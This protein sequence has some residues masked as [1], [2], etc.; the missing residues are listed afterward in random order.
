M[1]ADLSMHSYRLT[2]ALALLAAI[3]QPLSSEAAN[4]TWST[5]SWSPSQQ[6]GSGDGVFFYSSGNDYTSTLGANYTIFRLTVNNIGNR[7]IAPGG[8]NILTLSAFDGDGSPSAIQINAGAGAVLIQS[9]LKLDPND[10]DDNIISV[11]NEAGLTITQFATGTDGFTKEGNGTLFLNLSGN[12][13]IARYTAIERGTVE[14]TSGNLLQ[15]WNMG[16]AD[17]AGSN[18]TLN[19]QSG[20]MEVDGNFY[21]GEEGSGTVNVNG[22]NLTLD[23]QV[24]IGTG[25]GTA[26][27]NLNSGSLRQT[28]GW[29]SMTIGGGSGN[30]EL[31]ISGGDFAVAGFFSIEQNGTLNVSG[32]RCEWRIPSKWREYRHQ[33]DGW[34]HR[35][36][37]CGSFQRRRLQLGQR[38][39]GR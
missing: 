34:H 8:N 4:L 14:L 16:I 30:G 3:L 29:T 33:S 24:D 31:N 21:V 18:G 5:T 6:P 36:R 1:K 22:G 12:N 20:S 26:I 15:D 19:I 25:N 39:N 38:H 23:N 2:A 13:T 28:A 17:S 37:S 35:L 7:T 10:G 27:V 32:G 11:E 9:A